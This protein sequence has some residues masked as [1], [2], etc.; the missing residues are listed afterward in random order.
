M[1]SSARLS[2]LGHCNFYEIGIFH[3]C[4]TDIVHK[5]RS[6]TYSAMLAKDGGREWEKP[7]ILSV[8]INLFSR[9]REIRP[10]LRASA[11][12][13]RM[14]NQTCIRLPESV[15]YQNVENSRLGNSHHCRLDEGPPGRF[16]PVILTNICKLV[17]DIS[18]KRCTEKP[19]GFTCL[20]NL[21]YPHVHCTFAH[22]IFIFLAG[23]FLHFHFEFSISQ[24][25]PLSNLG[26]LRLSPVNLESCS[27]I[28]IIIIFIFPRSD[29]AP[30]M[31]ALL[32]AEG[33]LEDVIDRTFESDCVQDMQ[34]DGKTE[35]CGII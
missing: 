13:W 17:E 27:V 16:E 6:S 18:I 34:D 7:S 31:T 21:F 4:N 23:L 22:L 24:D 1:S 29:T 32:H 11:V 33:I 2:L 28:R 3:W 25:P 8:I 19:C 30:T 5:G 14:I 10:L 9:H 15:M 12:G 35:S 20:N 26:C